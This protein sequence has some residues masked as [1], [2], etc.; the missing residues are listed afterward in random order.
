MSAELG[1]VELPPRLA[2]AQN[3]PAPS[4]ARIMTIPDRTPVDLK[5]PR[6]LPLISCLC[7]YARGLSGTHETQGQPTGCLTGT[8]GA[9][10][11][12]LCS[13]TLPGLGGGKSET[14][15]RGFFRGG[16]RLRTHETQVHAGGCSPRE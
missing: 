3:A 1:V 15:R 4:S 13:R 8:S 12:A 5:A 14:T 2:N 16:R 7:R 9:D 10:P 6:F 11:V